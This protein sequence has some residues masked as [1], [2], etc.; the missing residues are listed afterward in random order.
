MLVPEGAVGRDVV[1]PAP[2]SGLA[3]VPREGALEVVWSP[4]PDAGLDGYRVYRWVDEG[5]RELVAEI[6]AGTTTWLDDTGQGGILY[7][8]TVTAVDAAGNEGPASGV[9]EGIRP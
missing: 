6:A 1:P 8:Y 5:E 7:R 3:V 9:A 4:S 2:P